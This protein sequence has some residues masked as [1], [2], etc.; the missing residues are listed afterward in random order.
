MKVTLAPSL[1]QGLP[2]AEAV[3]QAL[4]EHVPAR[5]ARLAM[6]GLLTGSSGF[7]WKSSSVFAVAS[8]EHAAVGQPLTFSAFPVGFPFSIVPIVSFIYV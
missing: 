1:L 5:S 8:V 3:H 7:G 2:G 4:P 6:A